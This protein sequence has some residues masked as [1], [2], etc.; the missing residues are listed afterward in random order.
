M[1]RTPF[2]TFGLDAGGLDAGE[3]KNQASV[4]FGVSL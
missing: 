2:P 4:E 1:V 3:M